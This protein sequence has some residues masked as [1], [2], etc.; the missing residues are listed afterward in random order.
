MKSAACD[1][2]CRPLQDVPAAFALPTR[3]FHFLPIEN[4]NSPHY[5]LRIGSIA[6]APISVSEPLKSIA[7]TEDFASEP[8]GDIE[9]QTTLC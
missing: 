3:A 6:V 7:V 5:F 1:H 4:R 9:C 8:A 2:T